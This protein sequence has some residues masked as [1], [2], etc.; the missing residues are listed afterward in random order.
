[1]TPFEYK[2]GFAGGGGG[3]EIAWGIVE[4]GVKLYYVCRLYLVLR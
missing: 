2:E 3:K 4:W 1:M